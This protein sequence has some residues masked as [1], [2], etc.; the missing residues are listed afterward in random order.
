MQALIDVILPVFLVIGA[1]YLA[2]RAG[3]FP[4]SAVDGLMKFAQNFAV[5]CLL[6]A[7]LA[8]LD[9]GANFRLELLAAFYTGALSCFVLGL[10]G[11]RLLFGRG[12]EDSVAIGF[13]ALFSN[14]VL[15]GLPIMERAFGPDALAGNYAIIAIHAPTCY[16]VGILA[17]ELVR[18]RDDGGMRDVPA[19]MVKSMFRNALVIGIALGFA[20]N[21][22]NVPLPQPFWDAVDLMVRAALPAAIFGLGGV[23]A[24]YRPEGD[25]RVVAL[26]CV[27]SLVLHPA[28]TYALGRA[29]G[30]STDAL[31]SAV[32]TAAMAPGLNSFLFA[33]AYGVALRVAATGVLVATALCLGTTWLWL[34]ILP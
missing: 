32:V 23:L 19:R 27:L 9:L 8:R 31:R 7:G 17:M 5:P 10:L 28:I 30:L 6:F 11:A 2:T 1:G 18:A 22:G 25:M 16:A 33:S 34:Q 26:V 12:W 29:F 20:V 21:L 3:F 24:R 4:A 13:G 15:L 14:T